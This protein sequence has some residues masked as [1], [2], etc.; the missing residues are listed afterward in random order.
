MTK[1]VLVTY[2]SRFGPTRDIA[3]AITATL[4][5]EGLPGAMQPM[6]TVDGLEPYGAVVMGAALYMYRWHEGARRFLTH[7][8]RS[9]M[10]R[11][12]AVFAWVPVK[13]PHDG[14]AW[15]A[16]RARLDKDL[17]WYGWLKP[18]AVQLF[19]SSFDATELHVPLDDVADDHGADVREWEVIRSWARGLGASLG[20]ALQAGPTA[21]PSQARSLSR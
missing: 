20:P 15:E 6:A 14:E 9:L 8:R 13:D 10:R 1:P 11:P 21:G 2:A 4:T 19:G 12:V 17:A 3:R 5:D 7:H 16:A 18:I